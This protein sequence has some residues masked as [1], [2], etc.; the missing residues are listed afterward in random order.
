MFGLDKCST[1]TA[2]NWTKRGHIDTNL[3]NCPTFFCKENAGKRSKMR[4]M[5]GSVRDLSGQTFI[6]SIL[7]HLERHIGMGLQVSFAI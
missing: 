6:L 1:L 7:A 2:Q 3:R 4:K 5:N